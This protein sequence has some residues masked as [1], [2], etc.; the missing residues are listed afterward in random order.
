MAVALFGAVVTIILSAE[1]G[2]VA[3][4]KTAANMSQA[5][6]LGRCRMSELEEKQ[7]KLGFPEIE[8]KDSSPVCCDDK[9]APGF[10][11]EWQVERVLLPEQTQ[12][13]GDAGFGSLLAGGL[14][15]DGGVGG[16]LAGG[17]SSLA[18]PSALSNPLGTAQ[19]DLDAGL[20]N[21]GQA[22]QQSLGGAGATGLLSMVFSLVYPS[23]KP[24]LEAAIRRI[25]VT[26]QWKEG[27][28]SRDFTVVQYVT[29][30]S[31]AGLL[32]GMPD[33]GAL[34]EGGLPAGIGAALGLPGLGGAAPA[35]TV[36]R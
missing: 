22:L 10:S 18:G 7:L 2:L 20:Q 27:T 35:P 6:E 14:D 12:L 32:A 23:L 19:L 26:V 25:T 29:N 24:L 15:L 1:V 9:E 4:N 16:L 36:P 21:M 28:A 8:E 33:G 13:G 17:P 11:C 3:G 31:R 34:G 5:I 30:P